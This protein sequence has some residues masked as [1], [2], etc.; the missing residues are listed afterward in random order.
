[1]AADRQFHVT[2][3]AYTC[4]Q[5]AV[6]ALALGVGA[7]GLRRTAK[8]G[9]VGADTLV[10]GGIL[11]GLVPCA[12]VVTLGA[13]G[14]TAFGVIGLLYA[15]CV[16][17]LPVLAAGVLA[18]TALRRVRLTRA[19]AVLALLALLG[20]PVGA[21]ATF[22]EPYRLR[23]ETPELALRDARAGSAPLRIGV[24]ADLQCDAVGAHERA[25]VDLLLAQRPDVI[26]VPGDVIQSTQAQFDA[27]RADLLALLQRLDA[28]AGVWFVVGDVDTAPTIEL[29]RETK[30]RVLFDQVVRFRVGDRDVTLGGIS[31]PVRAG[32][33]GPSARRV[34]D[35]L[36]DRPGAADVR[37]LMA[38]RPDVALAL[39]EDS[40]VDLVVAGHTHGGQ[41]VVP[42]FGPPMTLSAVPRDVARG[43]LHRLL[44]NA[45]YVSRGVGMERLQAPRLRLL[46]PPEVTLLTATGPASETP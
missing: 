43:G 1:M 41:V 2:P 20:A 5:I 30:V 35:E 24:L 38:H 18:A 9:V 32:H 29:L 28:P 17:V 42:G 45:V 37:I 46:A 26:L 27:A 10:R 22:V 14:L 6:A 3:F 13:V 15:F 36:E 33:V 11:A 4:V 12:A 39:A 25:A 16:V 34:L 40:R 8:P 19:A 21:W 31:S 44:G 7:W 23:L